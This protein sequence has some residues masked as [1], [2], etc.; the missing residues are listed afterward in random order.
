MPAVR[1]QP[2]DGIAD[3]DATAGPERQARV[4]L[5]QSLAALPEFDEQTSNQ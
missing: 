1:A 4:K 5:S 2:G 3:A